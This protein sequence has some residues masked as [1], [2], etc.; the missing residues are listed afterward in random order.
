MKK[1]L[2]IVNPISGNGRRTAIEHAIEKNID[3]NLFECELRT[4][5]YAGHA[6]EIAREAAAQGVHIVVAV[7]GDGTIN[8]VARALVHTDAALG[9][10]PC[11]SGNGLARH[12]RLPMDPSKATRILNQA[13]IHC[14]DYGKIN[15]RP[16]FC[17]CGVGFDALISMKFAESGKRGPLTYVENVLKEW[18]KYHPETYTVTGEN[19]TQTHKAVVVT[20]ANASQYGNNAYI[21]PFA[22]MKDG[23]LDVI[24]MEPFSTLEAPRLAMQLFSRKL[25][26]NSK[27]KAFRSRK[28]HIMRPNEGAIHCDGDPFMTGKEIEIEIIPHGLNIVVN[29]KAHNRQYTL[30]QIFGEGGEQWWNKQRRVFIRQQVK[31]RRLN[32]NILERLSKL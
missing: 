32:R 7:G 4:T 22:S 14:L 25:M 27:I 2:F 29:P 3:R 26:K 19:G 9:I 13:V 20:C 5:E 23:L 24:I 12:L 31:I 30:L 16:F 17:T 8:E 28:V 18:V 6:E 1:I 15:G 10:I 11:G 21:A